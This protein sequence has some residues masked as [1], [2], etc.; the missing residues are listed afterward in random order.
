[1][2][3]DTG[4]RSIQHHSGNSSTPLQYFHSL[5]SSSIDHLPT[6]QPFTDIEHNSNNI[7]SDF[8]SLLLLHTIPCLDSSL[9][10]GIEIHSKEQ[11]KRGRKHKSL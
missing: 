2:L 5:Y 4:A 1:M 9:L 8:A 7:L 11:A 10:I 3:C 6:K